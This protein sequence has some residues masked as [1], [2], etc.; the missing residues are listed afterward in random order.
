MDD[1]IERSGEQTMDQIHSTSPTPEEKLPITKRP[2]DPICT[3][4][5]G[6]FAY[7]EGAR[8]WLILAS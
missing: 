7:V 3:P 1:M 2:E 4:D 6:T 8:F 5:D